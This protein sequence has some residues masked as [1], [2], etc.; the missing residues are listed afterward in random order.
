[1]R[2]IAHVCENCSREYLPER[3][4]QRW[5]SPE[6]R[7]EYRA[8]EL[9]AARKLWAREGKPTLEMIEKQKCLNN[10]NRQR[11]HQPTHR[12]VFVRL[13]NPANRLCPPL[14]RAMLPLIAA[15]AKAKGKAKR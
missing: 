2:Y 15:G 6:C 10:P 5:C 8:A 12:E 13:N 14:V 7:D 1:M 11:A 4:R 3:E 9:R